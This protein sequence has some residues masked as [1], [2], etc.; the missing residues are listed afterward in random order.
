MALEAKVPR[1]GR[2]AEREFKHLNSRGLRAVIRRRAT[3]STFV[4]NIIAQGIHDGDFGR[5]DDPRSPR[6][7]SS[8]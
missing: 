7:H 1:T 8:S 6:P 5:D 2:V 3:F 4:K